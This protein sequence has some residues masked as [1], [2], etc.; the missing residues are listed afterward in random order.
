MRSLPMP[1]LTEKVSSGIAY[2]TDIALRDATGVTIAFTGRSGGVSK[3]AYSGLNISLAVG[4]SRDSVL[5]NRGALLDALDG[6]GIKMLVP[7][8]VHGNNVISITDN[9]QD[10]I[11][12]VQEMTNLRAD[13]LVVSAV[14]VAALLG[15]ADCVPLIIVSPTGVFAVVHAGWR[16][17]VSKIAINA[18]EEMSRLDKNINGGEAGDVSQYNV[19]IGPHIKAC[20]FEVGSEVQE[21]FA[22]DFGNDT[23]TDD[24]HV[25]LDRA[26]RITLESAGVE[27]KRIASVGYCTMCHPE[28]FFSYRASNGVCGRHGAIAFRKA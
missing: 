20:C 24:G 25:D 14:D 21:Q 23:L 22:C 9:S 16:G 15:F 1:E 26:L 11:A 8:Q 27:P 2:F 19:Y 7:K 18:I 5:Q 17:V 4:D 12:N 13:G 10:Y 28:L 6:A 3:D